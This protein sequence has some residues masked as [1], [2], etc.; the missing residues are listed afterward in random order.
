MKLKQIDNLEILGPVDC[1]P[2]EDQKNFRS[3]LLIR[4]SKHTL[5][6]KKN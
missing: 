6:Q 2:F 3:R 1:A 4:L 5:M